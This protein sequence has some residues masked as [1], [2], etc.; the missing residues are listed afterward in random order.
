MNYTLASTGG[1]SLSYPIKQIEVTYT[2]SQLKAL[3]TSPLEILPA[4]KSYGIINACLKYNNNNINTGQELWI[5]YENMLAPAITSEQ[6]RITTGTMIGQR[7]I[8]SI[9]ANPTVFWY[10]STNPT[11]PLVL[12]QQFDDGSIDFTEFRLILTYI[13]FNL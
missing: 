6:I 12:W 11:Q 4:G 10:E 8:L 5:G 9:S 13:E 2:T 3:N 7:G 1:G